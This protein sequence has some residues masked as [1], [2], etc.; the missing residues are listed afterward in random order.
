MNA[1][2]EC[3]EENE[4]Q[5]LV[6]T[7]VKQFFI[8]PEKLFMTKRLLSLPLCHSMPFCCRLRPSKKTEN[9]RRQKANVS[10]F[11]Y[12]NGI[13]RKAG[14]ISSSKQRGSSKTYLFSR[15]ISLF[16]FDRKPLIAG[17]V[18]ADFFSLF[19]IDFL[20]C[21]LKRWDK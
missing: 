5:D 10:T 16:V 1:V 7:Y 20:P 2:S 4:Q 8:P 9:Q 12:A 14:N 13:C 21:L 3:Q 15:P 17:I 18:V 19:S 6:R 11:F